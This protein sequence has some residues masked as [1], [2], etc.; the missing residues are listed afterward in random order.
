MWGSR[1]GSDEHGELER[2]L[3]A[4]RP[5]APAVLVEAVT[6]E[7]TR[8]HEGARVWSRLAFAA[9][10]T[11]ILLGA[12]VSFGGV[13]YTT[14][15]TS[16]AYKT[17][18]NL[19]TAKPVR[20]HSAADAQYPHAP[21]NGTQAATANNNQAAGAVVEQQQGT[22]PFTGISLLATVLVALALIAV[23]FALRAR[24]RRNV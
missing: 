14:S 16:H 2:R 23:G 1:K 10:F 13:G 3:R 21:T 5:Q 17:V 19:S 22:L 9:A 12:F 7:L 8:P 24:E 20:V 11:T 15:A 6:A 18:K 4:E